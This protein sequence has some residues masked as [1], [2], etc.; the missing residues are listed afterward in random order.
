MADWWMVMSIRSQHDSSPS[1]SHLSLIQ[2]IDFAWRSCSQKGATAPNSFQKPQPIVVPTG[3]GAPS[4]TLW[5]KWN[6][7]TSPLVVEGTSIYT[8]CLNICPLDECLGSLCSV[9]SNKKYTGKCRPSIGGERS[10]GEY[11]QDGSRSAIGLYDEL[12]SR[13]LPARTDNKAAP[14]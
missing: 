2:P 11:V 7:A 6:N 13:P 1:P 12:H 5:A 4:N 3:G 8:V 9:H 10:R 14:F